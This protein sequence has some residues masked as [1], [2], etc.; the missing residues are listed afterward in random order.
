M[1]MLLIAALALVSVGALAQEAPAVTAASVKI[2]TVTKTDAFSP[3]VAYIGPDVKLTFPNPIAQL[4][5]DK[6]SQSLAIECAK[7]SGHCTYM[8][9]ITVDYTD[10]NWRFINSASLEGGAALQ[11]QSLSRDVIDCGGAFDD[12]PGC[13][14]EESVGAIL[15]SGFLAS[16]KATGFQLKVGQH[17][18]TIS[19]AYVQGFLSAVPASA[20]GEQSLSPAVATGMR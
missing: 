10:A 3:D 8:V 5:P 9:I 2:A 20:M 6:V 16:H 14:Y 19:S 17:I 4:P 18:Y 13:E 12:S 15:T 11:V 7:K 1:K